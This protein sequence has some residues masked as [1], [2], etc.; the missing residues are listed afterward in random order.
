MKIFI[1]NFRVFIDLLVTRLKYE[2]K[3]RSKIEEKT[4]RFFVN[5]KI[6]SEEKGQALKSDGKHNISYL[7]S[8]DNF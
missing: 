7:S 2:A 5:K 3:M 4:L 8:V 1:S 6:P